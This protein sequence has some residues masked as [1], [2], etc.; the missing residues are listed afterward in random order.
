MMNKLFALLLL[1]PTLLFAGNGGRTRQN[2]NHQEDSHPAVPHSKKS[3]RERIENGLE[4]GRLTEGEYDRLI[5]EQAELRSFREGINADG[6]VTQQE[7]DALKA[8]R[9]EQNQRIYDQKHDDQFEPEKMLVSFQ[10]R[11][12]NGV[13]NRT[14]TGDEF[15]SVD[16]L[17]Q[18]AKAK[19]AEAN[20]DGIVSAE[21]KDAMYPFYQTLHERIRDLKHDDDSPSR[22]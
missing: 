10:E 16:A 6:N 2:T 5:R 15:T 21:E 19:Y 4:N 18:E 13:S 8:L 20:A 14:L 9:E 12:I 7:R 1:L 11:I 3:F 17:Y 22:D